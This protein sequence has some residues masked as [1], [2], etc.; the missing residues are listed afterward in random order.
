[1]PIVDDLELPIQRVE[2]IGPAVDALERRKESD[3]APPVISDDL[4]RWAHNARQN[5]REL[6]A[7]IHDDLPL[8]KRGEGQ[9]MTHADYPIPSHAAYVWLTGDTLQVGLP[10][11]P[12]H[13]KGHTVT[14][15]ADARGAARLISI[16]QAR[17]RDARRTIGTQGCP[18]QYDLDKI[19]SAMVTEDQKRAAREKREMRAAEADKKNAER[20]ERKLAELREIEAADALLEELGL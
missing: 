15:P 6:A 8:T 14:L 10:P 13:D 3:N 18:T 20:R 2:I 1:M 5:S 19:A 12:G 17:Q 16:L 9:A 11:T 7:F 4:R